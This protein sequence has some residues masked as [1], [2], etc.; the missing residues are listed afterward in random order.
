MR[1]VQYRSTSDGDDRSGGCAFAIRPDGELP[2]FQRVVGPIS[3]RRARLNTAYSETTLTGLES[4]LAAAQVCDPGD[5]GPKSRQ[6][7]AEFLSRWA[8]TPSR[9]AAY[10]PRGSINP[11]AG[12]R[13]SEC[14]P[15]CHLATARDRQSGHGPFSLTGQPNAMGRAQRSA[16]CPTCWPII[17]SLECPAHRDAVV[18]GGV[19][20]GGVG[21]GGV[22]VVCGWCVV[23][24]W[25]WLWWSVCGGGGGGVVWWCGV[26]AWWG[27][28]WV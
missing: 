28:G 25:V 3:Q 1:I 6:E 20:W 11:S 27:D 13:Q 17:L 4:A 7:L 5:S 21:V 2:W 22:G 12:Q 8:N 16:A 9:H 14:D 10:S 18:G 23:V 24:W 19:R 15:D 26:C